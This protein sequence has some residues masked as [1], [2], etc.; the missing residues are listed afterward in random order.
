[1]LCDLPIG[2]QQ[3]IYDQLHVCD[4]VRM[5]MA[6]PRH[7]RKALKCESIAKEKKLFVVSRAI[8]QKRVTKLSY[9]MKEFLMT[10]RD[11]DPTLDPIKIMFPGQ[12]HFKVTT[13]TLSQLSPLDELK[14]KIKNGT[15][16][17]SNLKHLTFDVV[18]NMHTY[19]TK[20]TQ[21]FQALT[22]CSVSVFEFIYFNNEPFREY[23]QGSGSGSGSEYEYVRNLL[24]KGEAGANL[25]QHLL[26]NAIEY[27]IDTATMMTKLVEYSIPQHGI[28]TCMWN[29]CYKNILRFCP[30]SFD[31]LET[32]WLYCIEHMW[33]DAAY[34]VGNT[35]QSL[36]G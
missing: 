24:W 12:V 27:K 10:C 18:R 20:F 25:L 32:I 16:T 28:I 33:I 3:L 1:M 26:D 8:A 30:L 31:D 23:V 14:N 15:V 9:A 35:L 19:N 13:S 22:S 11:T 6:V 34:E 36:N 5:F 21:L 29:C 17:I 4:R 2:V 7:V